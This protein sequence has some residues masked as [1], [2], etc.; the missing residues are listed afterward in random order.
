M[1]LGFM[2]GKWVEVKMPSPLDKSWSQDDH[3]TYISIFIKCRKMGCKEDRASQI[4][5]A[6]VFQMKYEGLRY[7]PSFEKEIKGLLGTA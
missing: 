4:A 1:V 5:E 7:E 3:F 6:V 2:N